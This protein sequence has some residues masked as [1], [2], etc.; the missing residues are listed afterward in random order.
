[1]AWVTAVSLIL[2]LEMTAN[3]LLIGLKIHSIETVQ[4]G[5]FHLYHGHRRFLGHSMK[6]EGFIWIFLIFVVGYSLWVSFMVFRNASLS[7][8]Q[9][10]AQITICLLVPFFGAFFIQMFT[11]FDG[12]APKKNPNGFTE[13]GENDA[14]PMD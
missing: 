5:P 11:K 12:Q 1:V 14:G 7:R 3:H 9:K 10:V 4:V 6:L 8:I 13:Q 2:I